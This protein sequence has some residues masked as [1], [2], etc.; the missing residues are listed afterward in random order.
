M[1]STL[2][3]RTIKHTFNVH[4]AFSLLALLGISVSQRLFTTSTSRRKTPTVPFNPHRDKAMLM[5]TP[6]AL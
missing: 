6:L 4:I 5:D 2:E 1:L 3:T